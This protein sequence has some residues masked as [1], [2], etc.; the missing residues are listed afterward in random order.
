MLSSLAAIP[1]SPSEPCSSWFSQSRRSPWLLLAP[2]LPPGFL[3]DPTWHTLVLGVC[4]VSVQTKGSPHLSPGL[5]T[6]QCLLTSHPCS[7]SS[8]TGLCKVACLH[9]PPKPVP[10]T[11]GKAD[12]GTGLRPGLVPTG[13]LRMERAMCRGFAYQAVMSVHFTQAQASCRGLF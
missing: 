7:S 1:L 10:R 3:W 4:W 2:P 12:G 9:L 8:P 11:D 6:H 13:Q 5:C